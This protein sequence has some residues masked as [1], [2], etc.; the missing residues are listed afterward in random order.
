MEGGASSGCAP[1]AVEALERASPIWWSTS[2]ALA[3][4]LWE[5]PKVATVA[6]SGGFPQGSERFVP[7]GRLNVKLSPYAAIPTRLPRLWVQQFQQLG[8][9][10]E[11]ALDIDRRSGAQRGAP[12]KKLRPEVFLSAPCIFFVEI[13]SLALPPSP[14]AHPRFFFPRGKHTRECRDKGSSGQNLSGQDQ[15]LSQVQAGSLQ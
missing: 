13:Q 10:N 4:T 1:G 15:L 7:K 5:L 8:I 9:G 2:G 3:P 11:D 12:E 14:T 6:D